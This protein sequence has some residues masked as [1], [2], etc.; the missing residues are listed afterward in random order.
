MSVIIPPYPKAIKTQILMAIKRKGRYSVYNIRSKRKRGIIQ[1]QSDMAAIHDFLRECPDELSDVFKMDESHKDSIARSDGPM[2]KRG[3]QCG[4]FFFNDIYIE[5]I[6]KGTVW[7]EQALLPI[8]TQM[9]NTRETTIH[10]NGQQERMIKK[11]MELTGDKHFEKAVQRLFT[12]IHSVLQGT[13]PTPFAVF[14]AH[15]T[16]EKFHLMSDADLNHQI[17]QAVKLKL[18]AP[19]MFQIK[20]NKSSDHTAF[21]KDIKKKLAEG[22]GKF[23]V[24]KALENT[25]ELQNLVPT[26]IPIRQGIRMSK[27]YLLKRIFRKFKDRK[28]CIRR[29]K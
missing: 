6:P 19:P 18:D 9:E 11:W 24:Q 22:Y 2:W 16:G 14:I 27:T 26:T 28:I 23:P 13:L 8:P 25:Q 4:D 15:I 5:K 12:G 29:K 10:I 1:A 17:E 20:R 21:E 3:T 7:T